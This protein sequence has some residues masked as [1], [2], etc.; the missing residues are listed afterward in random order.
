GAGRTGEG[1]EAD[2]SLTEASIAT[3]A[4]EAS[5]YLATGS[6]PQPLGNRHRLNAAYQLFETRDGRHLAI[7]TSN[8]AGFARLMQVLGLEA[9]ISDPRFATY[10]S[11][12][13]NEDPL[14]ELVEPAVHKRDVVELQ[15]ALVEAGLPCSRVNNFK[16][17]FED[18]H[19]IARGV[20][21]DDEHPRLGKMR[22][23]RN[24]IV[25][26]HDGPDISR[27]APLLGEHSEELLRELG[28]PAEKIAELFAS[29]V[30]QRPATMP[31]SVQAA[32]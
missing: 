14:L 16:E 20:L 15:A 3:A 28:Y 5:E 21:K 18:P 19:I 23:V 1:R 6:I 22:V 29:K 11:R 26:D 30:T 25:L 32:E 31:Q 4:W 8:D 17:V 27:H 12:K 9:H 7:G 24:P 2:V 10:A 13:A